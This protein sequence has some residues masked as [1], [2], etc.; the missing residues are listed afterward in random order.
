MVMPRATAIDQA[1]PG[2]SG[3]SAN[4]S[5]RNS[6]SGNFSTDSVGGRAIHR[7]NHHRSALKSPPPREFAPGTF[8]RTRALD[9]VFEA[10]ADS[11]AIQ[12]LSA[13]KGGGPGLRRPYV[14]R[15]SGET[16]KVTTS[17]VS[18]QL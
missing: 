4:T 5:R 9:F 2:G 10:A 14:A 18:A 13:S 16:F 1:G 7:M 11:V 8:D 6:A 17:P 15:R 3:A 12:P